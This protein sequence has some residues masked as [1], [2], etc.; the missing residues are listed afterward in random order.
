MKIDKLTPEQEAHLDR[1]LDECLV[2][3]R[4][5][6]PV[7]HKTAEDT[8]GQT[9]AL[10]DRDRPEFLWVQSPLEGYYLQAAWDKIHPMMEAGHVF[11]P[12]EITRLGKEAVGDSTIHEAVKQQG[13]SVVQPW[14]TQWGWW[15]GGWARFAAFPEKHIEGF[16]YEPKDSE[17]LAVWNRLADETHLM[18]VFDGLAVL[19]ERPTTLQLNEKGQLHCTYGPAMKYSDGYSLYSLH[20]VALSD[21]QADLYIT[22]RHSLKA[23]T[24]LAESNTEVRRVVAHYLFGWERL[25]DEIDPE[26]LDENDGDARLLRVHLKGDDEPIHFV[27]LL[28]HTCENCVEQITKCSCGNTKRKRYIEGVPNTVMTVMDAHAWRWGLDSL[29]PEHL[30]ERA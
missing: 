14:Y 15:S 27:D 17:A 11:E 1:Y 10:M 12:G 18:W 30:G 25:I 9:Y 24:V 20:G 3:G 26:V 13:S 28:N 7:D 21:E 29:K 2:K 19:C 16:S 8:V 22:N 6:E 5:I 23:E 4:S